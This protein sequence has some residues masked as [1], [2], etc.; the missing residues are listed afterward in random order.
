MR[1]QRMSDNAAPEGYR[2][3][4]QLSRNRYGVRVAPSHIPKSRSFVPYS[5]V[6]LAAMLGTGGEP[7]GRFLSNREALGYPIPGV[8]YPTQRGGKTAVTAES[9]NDRL[10]NVRGIFKASV[11]ELAE[12]FGVARQTIYNWQAGEAIAQHNTALIDQLA[13]AANMLTRARVDNVP[14]LARRKLPGGLTLF[15]TIRAGEGGEAAAAKLLVLVARE[16]EQAQALSERLD[17]RPRRSVNVDEISL[18]HLDEG[19]R[20]A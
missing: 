2:A 6:L 18:P 14:F 1:L 8:Q 3:W 9:A 17:R 19:D 10:S 20:P 16:R 13:K 15:G 5:G 4:T 11:T 7:D 12:W